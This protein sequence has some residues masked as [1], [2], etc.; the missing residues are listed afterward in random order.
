MSWPED[1][2]RL[3]LVATDGSP[4]SRRAADTAIAVARRHGSEILFL[5]VVDD[6]RLRELVAA[7]PGNEQEM[8]KRLERS[9]EQVVAEL[10][11]RARARDVPAHTR[12]GEGDPPRVIDEVA[13][14]T[15]ADLIFVGKVGQRGVRS[16]F[17]GSVTRRLVEGTR[18]PVVVIP[19]SA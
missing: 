14:E 3:V 16:W 11:A 15:G 5:H 19:G 17:V 6:D 1:P 12:V 7:V 4:T 13:R 10:A 9:A 8:R 2:P 18:V